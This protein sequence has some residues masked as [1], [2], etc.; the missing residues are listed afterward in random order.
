[1]KTIEAEVTSNEGI[2][3]FYFDRLYRFICK[4]ERNDDDDSDVEITSIPLPGIDDLTI[5]IGYCSPDFAFL[6]GARER[7][8]RGM[9]SRRITL[10]IAGSKVQTH[11]SAKDALEKIA[12]SIFFQIDLNFEIAMNLQSQRESYIDRRNKRMRKQKSIDVSATLKEPKYE[13][14]NEPISLYWYA[15]ESANMPIF[16]FLAYYQSIEFYFPIYSSFEAK[17]KIQSLIKD[18]RFNPHLPHPLREKIR[19]KNPNK[20]GGKECLGVVYQ[21]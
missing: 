9:H 4:P 21:D 16:Q 15:K 17:Q 6:T 2:G 1:M 19:N 18:P 10:K 13:Y 8:P 3:R 7:G 14:D 5:S 12:N 11:D 20:K